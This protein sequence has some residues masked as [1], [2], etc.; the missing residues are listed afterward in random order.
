MEPGALTRLTAAILGLAGFALSIVAGVVASNPLHT[1][2][3]R[4]LSAMLVCAVVGVVVG[5]MAESVVRQR[6][7]QSS[8][9][10]ASSPGAPKGAAPG[11]PVTHNPINQT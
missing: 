5:A 9:R 2:V 6:I 1:S 3:T 10:R 8:P 4:A 7:A 11:A